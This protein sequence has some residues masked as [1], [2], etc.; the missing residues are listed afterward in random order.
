MGSILSRL[1]RLSALSFGKKSE[2]VAARELR[3]MGY[4]I[5]E[6]NFRCREGEIDIVAREGD[7]VIFCEVKARRS[8]KFGTALEGVTP[9]KIAKLRKAAEVYINKN[10]LE[11]V[12]ARFDVVAIDEE[13]GE[14]KLEVIRNA[15]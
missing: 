2:Q 4:E 7:T 15:F 13:R 11:K 1:A 12:D 3:R 5:I 6:M 10:R 9:A 8:D 14:R